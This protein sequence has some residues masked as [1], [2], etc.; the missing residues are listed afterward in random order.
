MG[1]HAGIF[2]AAAILSAPIL[3]AGKG[4]V[5]AQS[6]SFEAPQGTNIKIETGAQYA[7]KNTVMA[8]S[9]NVTRFVLPD[10]AR[11][12]VIVEGTG[13]S[14]CN[15]YAFERASASA[16]WEKRL[17]TTGTLGMNGMSNHRHS[18]DKTTPIGVFRMDTP[19]GQAKA[20]LGFPSDYIQ[21]DDTYVWTDDTNKLS[22]DL[23][24]SG[25]RVGSSG[26]AG[27]YDYAIDSG[28][29]PNGIENQGFALFLHCSGDFKDYTSGCVAIEKDAMIQ[30]MRLYGAHGSGASFIAQAPKGTF[31]QI[32][33][34]YGTNG[35][36]SPDGEF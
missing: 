36:L 2:M 31:D 1:I 20:L 30:I 12:L 4:Q 6:V 34:T 18:G 35:G 25:E 32:Y 9:A 27:Y 7:G 19:F 17:E 22:R 33:Q 26:Y 13:G 10:E 5:Q 24:K 29:N 28:F 16:A 11:V 21:V 23:T 15:V 8:G 14:E 3:T